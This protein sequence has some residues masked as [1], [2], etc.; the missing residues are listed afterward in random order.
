ME[1]DQTGFFFWPAK[2]IYSEIHYLCNAPT[3]SKY[4]LIPSKG[5]KEKHL[6]WGRNKKHNKKTFCFYFVPCVLYIYY[7]ILILW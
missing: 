4:K 1:K 5:N 2:N 3:G 6:K 7:N